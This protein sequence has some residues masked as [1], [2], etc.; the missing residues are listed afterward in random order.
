MPVP[1]ASDTKTSDPLFAQAFFRIMSRERARN[2]SLARNSALLTDS[3]PGFHPIVLR[4]R[5][6]P[7]YVVPV[8]FQPVFADGRRGTTVPLQRLLRF[9]IAIGRYQGRWVLPTPPG[10]SCNNVR[11]SF[12]C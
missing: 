9:T 3:L 10:R 11:S 8:V 2:V 5:L 1:I 12:S 6:A 4:P 7:S